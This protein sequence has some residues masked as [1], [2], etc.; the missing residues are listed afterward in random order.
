MH[1]DPF[2]DA[3]AEGGDFSVFDPD[4]GEA[5]T[6]GGGDAVELA[7]IDENGFEG[8]Q[9]Q[10]EVASALVE[11]EYG[12]ANELAGAVVGGLAAAVGLD[13]GEGELLACEEAGLVAGASD[14][15][16]GFVF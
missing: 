8:S 14:C 7:K 13:D 9:I 10:V 4:A 3:D 5:F 16:D 2:A 1:G 6:P 12:V 11:V 15:I